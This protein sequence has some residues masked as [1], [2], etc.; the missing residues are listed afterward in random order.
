MIRWKYVRFA[1]WQQFYRIYS[2]IPFTHVFS[3]ITR[4]CS[5]F[6]VN[7]KTNCIPDAG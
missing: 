5:V 3:Q 7:E 1:E 4:M 2:V 6:T